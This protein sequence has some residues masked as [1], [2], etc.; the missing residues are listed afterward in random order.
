MSFK[1]LTVVDREDDSEYNLILRE[2]RL[3][4]E[5]GV[6][7]EIFRENLQTL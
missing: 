5:V 1:N 3:G 2:R 7:N 4:Y 6:A